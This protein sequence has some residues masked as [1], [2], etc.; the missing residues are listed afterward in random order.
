MAAANVT[1]ALLTGAATEPTPI[2]GRRPRLLV[3]DSGIGGLSVLRAIRAARPDADVVYLA[4]DANFPYGDWP[5]DALKAHIVAL[6]GTWIAETH[7]DLVVIACNTASTLVMA[8]LRAQ[9]SL[10][11]VGTV[12][13]IK[14]AA[15]R[16]ESGLVSVLATPGTVKRD[17]TRAL[18]AEF[19]A[20]VAVNLVGSTRLARLAEAEMAGWPVGDDALRAE[21]A[22]CFVE[23]EGRRTDVVVL[24]CTHYPFLLPQF[25]RLAPWPVTWIDPAPAIGRRVV[26]LIGAP[27][28]MWDDLGRVEFRTTTGKALPEAAFTAVANGH[29]EADPARVWLET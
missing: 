29:T 20:D 11:F 6:L 7:P 12:P 2:L 24:A 5:A 18:I 19:A 22:P 28:A 15:E 14:T 16:T 10:P 3:F 17:Y 8:D 23:A 1:G 9:H 25:R 27:P 4:D 21:L 26:H 13:A